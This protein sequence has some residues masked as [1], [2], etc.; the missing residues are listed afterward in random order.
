M[1]RM[2]SPLASPSPA[3]LADLNALLAQL[4]PGN[5]PLAAA[6]LAEILASPAHTLLVA[7]NAHGRIVGQ[8]LLIVNRKLSGRQAWIEDVA[9]DEAHRGQGLGEALVRA[10]VERAR[11]RGASA[12]Y[13]TSRPSREA[14]NRLYLRLGFEKRETNVYRLGLAPR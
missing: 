4:S 3:D 1:P 5:P 11:T 12:V 9:V 8:T 7:R 6:A 10:A 13:L 2:I 14:A